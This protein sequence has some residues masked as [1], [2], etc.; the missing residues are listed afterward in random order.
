MGGGGRGVSPLPLAV[1]Q[2]TGSILDPKAAVDGP[3]HELPEYT[4]KFYLK[5]TSGV[6]GGGVN[7][8][9]KNFGPPKM[10]EY[11]SDFDRHAIFYWT[12]LTGH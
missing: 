11:D 3:R 5:F 10:S 1:F 12:V 6:T 9:S 7:R 4:A 8:E 2:C